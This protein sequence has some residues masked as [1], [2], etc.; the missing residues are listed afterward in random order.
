VGDT[1]QVQITSAKS[2][3]M[4]GKLAGD[5]EEGNLKKTEIFDAAFR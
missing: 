3:Q 4:E 5:S 2:W 1:V